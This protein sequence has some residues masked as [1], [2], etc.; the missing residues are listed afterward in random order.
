MPRAKRGE[1]P[2]AALEEEAIRVPETVRLD[3]LLEELRGAGFQ[4]AIVVDEYGGTAGIVTLEDLVEELVGEVADEHDRA[5][6]GIIGG[7][8]AFTFPASLR[9]DEARE[10]TGIVVPEDGPYD[11][12]AGYVLGELGRLPVVGDS[13]PVDA[14]RLTV[15]RMEGRRIE[16]LRFTAT[17]TEEAGDE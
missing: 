8:D 13:V 16:R 6:A 15:T 4:M 5:H 10:Q 14:G 2:V 17:P 7:A 3:V 9:P 12:I 1:V 11:T